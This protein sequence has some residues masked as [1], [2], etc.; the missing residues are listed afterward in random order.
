MRSLRSKVIYPRY[1]VP[2]ERFLPSFMWGREKS[3]FL[4]YDTKVLFLHSTKNRGGEVDQLNLDVCLR[5]RDTF[6]G[7]QDT[8]INIVGFI[9]SFRMLRRLKGSNAIWGNR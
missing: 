2:T 3:R 9:R 5:I 6:V 4:R 8:C 1:D 7:F